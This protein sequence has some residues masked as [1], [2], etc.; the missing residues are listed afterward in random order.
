M[1][2]EQLRQVEQLKKYYAF[3]EKTKVFDVVLHYEKASDLFDKNV[4]SISVPKMRP[5]FIERIGDIVHDIPKGYKVDISLAIDD[6]EDYKKK[7]VLESFNDL[8]ET[9]KYRFYKE[10]RL[11]WLQV[12]LLVLVGVSVLFFSTLASIYSWWGLFKNDIAQTVTS[13]VLSITSWVFIWESVSLIFI[14]RSYYLR[15]GSLIIGKVSSIALYKGDS[16]RAIAKETSDEM[17]KHLFDD[18]KMSHA[19]DLLLLFAGFA[20]IALTFITLVSDI[21]SFTSGVDKIPLVLFIANMVF[22][23]IRFVAGFNAIQL[24]L[25]KDNYRIRVF[26][27]AMMNTAIIIFQIVMTCTREFSVAGLIAEIGSTLALQ[28]YVLG[29]IFY[30]ISHRVEIAEKKQERREKRK[31]KKQK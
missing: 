2:K 10:N 4:E 7:D 22:Y 31:A 14:K 12:A 28:A 13:E 18:N 29:Y 17:V 27:V 9:I 8:L 11:K 24:S 3:N 1:N 19:S 21:V 26:L 15:T 30:R 25:G 6:Y 20:T 16:N 5:E 23:C